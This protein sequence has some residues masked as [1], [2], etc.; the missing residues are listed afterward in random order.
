MR[1]K[2]V[3]LES[4][5]DENGG[6]EWNGVEWK[7]RKSLGGELEGWRDQITFWVEARCTS[8]LN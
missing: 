1:R 4:G 7:E 8:I 6:M 2:R 3:G 5:D